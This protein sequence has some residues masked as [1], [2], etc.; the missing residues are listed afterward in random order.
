MVRKILN[1]LSTIL[2]L[3]FRIFKPFRYYWQRIYNLARA[4]AELV[5]LPVSVQFDGR[6]IIT[7]TKKIF[8]DSESRIG[9]DTELG[10]EEAGRIKIGRRVRVNRGGTIF[11]YADISIDDDTMIGEF[12]TIRDAN[13]GIEAGKSVHSQ[14]HQ[15]EA[16]KIGKDVWIGRGAVILPGVNIGDGAIIGANSVVTKSIAAG[17]IAVGSPAKVIRER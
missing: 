2:A 14:P 11:A 4:K 17:M 5:N 12:A 13:H 10:T 7:G 1:I 9:A 16:I 3:L 6:V 8:I 15:A